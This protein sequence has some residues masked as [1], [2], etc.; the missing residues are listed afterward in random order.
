MFIICDRIIFCYIGFLKIFTITTWNFLIYAP[1]K[2]MKVTGSLAFRIRSGLILWYLDV[3]QT[4]HFLSRFLSLLGLSRH[5]NLYIYFMEICPAYFLLSVYIWTKLI[6]WFV[7]KSLHDQSFRY[8]EIDALVVQPCSEDI[9]K[10]INK[11]RRL[12]V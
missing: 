3:V 8:Y 1:T 12:W 5:H 9:I 11:K 6:C 10:K 2:L 4:G 7:G